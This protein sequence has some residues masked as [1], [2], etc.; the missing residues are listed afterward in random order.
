MTEWKKF[1]RVLDR[2][3]DND[4]EK[5]RGLD[6]IRENYDWRVDERNVGAV[7]MDSNS[8]WWNEKKETQKTKSIKRSIVCGHHL[9][10]D[11]DFYI[12]NNRVKP[13]IRNSYG[14]WRSDEKYFIDK[15]RA[16][17]IWGGL[18]NKQEGI[19]EEK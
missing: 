9:E 6:F 10:W 12:E 1:F 7:L 8:N 11:E 14:V 17:D 2:E 16:V 5:T 13:V 15:V 4:N 19:M 3:A 18:K